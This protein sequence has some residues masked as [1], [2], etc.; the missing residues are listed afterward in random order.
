MLTIEDC[1][2]A[3]TFTKTH[4]V[5][6]ELVAKKNSKLLE[7]NKLE[8]VFVDI[9]GGLVP[10]FIPKNGITPRNHSTV[11]IVIEDLD[12]EAKAQRFIGCDIYIPMKDAPEF[13]EEADDLDPNLLIGFLYIDEEKGEL[14]EI[15]DIQDYSGNIVLVISVNNQEVLIPFAEENFIEINEE[16]KTITM[17]TPDG[18]IDMYLSE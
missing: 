7:K 10:F 14:G 17:E 9:D 13:I 6:G 3:G 15:E 18:L 2:L 16:N 5:K 1:Y 12:S 8:S 11:R 4:G